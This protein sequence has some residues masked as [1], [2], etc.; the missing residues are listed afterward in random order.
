[1]DILWG[2]VLKQRNYTKCDPN[3]MKL[4]ENSQLNEEEK[5]PEYHLNWDE[6]VDFLLMVYFC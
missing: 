3:I 5:L 1:M 4:D 2:K 6:I